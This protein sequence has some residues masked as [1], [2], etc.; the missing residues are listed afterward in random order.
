MQMAVDVRWLGHS[1]FELT[2]GDTNVV[3]DPCLTGNPKAAVSAD[4]LNPQGIRRTHGHAD[5]YGDTIDIAKRT[6][7]TVVAITEI[8]DELNGEDGVEAIDCNFGG[9]AK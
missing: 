6:G 9:T 5:H 8:A 1:A 2:A 4:E 3:V 7:A